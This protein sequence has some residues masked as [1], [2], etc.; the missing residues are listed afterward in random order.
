M[1]EKTLVEIVSGLNDSK[2]YRLAEI[3]SGEMN[4]RLNRPQ[5]YRVNLSDIDTLNDFSGISLLPDSLKTLATQ[6]TRK[7]TKR[8]GR[9]KTTPLHKK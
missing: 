9:T 4:H 2:L 7:T 8:K 3:V 5:K 6:R 1:G